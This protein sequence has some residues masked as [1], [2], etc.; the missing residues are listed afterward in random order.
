MEFIA[1]NLVEPGDYLV[2]INAGST[3]YLKNNT[4]ATAVYV[5]WLEYTVD[6]NAT[7]TGV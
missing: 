1:G 7:W 2:T 4:D 3:V 6:P 5:G